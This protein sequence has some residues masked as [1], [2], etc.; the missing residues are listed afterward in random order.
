MFNNNFNNFNNFKSHNIAGINKTPSNIAGVNKNPMNIGGINKMPKQN[1]P[2]SNVKM[3][4]QLSKQ[5]MNSS[6]ENVIRNEFNQGGGF[7]GGN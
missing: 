6:G 5:I 4:N 2:F 3:D 7:N 1:N